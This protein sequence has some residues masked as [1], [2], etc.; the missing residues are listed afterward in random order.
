MNKLTKLRLL[1]AVLIATAISPAFAIDVTAATGM[2]DSDAT[3][4]ITTIGQSMM[5][6][7]GLAIAFKWA[8]A[9]IFG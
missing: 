4:A 1:L 6:L 5:G 8:K 9:S 3:D 2:I 7:A